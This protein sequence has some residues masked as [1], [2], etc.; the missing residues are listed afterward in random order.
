MVRYY[1]S[2]V[3]ADTSR[4]VLGTRKVGDPLK[5]MPEDHKIEEAQEIYFKTRMEN[6][7]HYCIIN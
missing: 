6:N 2:A 1:W 7:S 4:L 5:S 3:T